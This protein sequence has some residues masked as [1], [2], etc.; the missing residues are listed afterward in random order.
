MVRDGAKLESVCRLDSGPAGANGGVPPRPSP[1]GTV[2]AQE[3]RA[4]FTAGA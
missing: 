1:L 4:G 2:M 3:G